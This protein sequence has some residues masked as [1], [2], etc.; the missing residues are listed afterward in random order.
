[1][2]STSSWFS[3]LLHMEIYTSQQTAQGLLL[4]STQKFI[5]ALA[6]RS[7][8]GYKKGKVFHLCLAKLKAAFLGTESPLLNQ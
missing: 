6:Y 1:M 4:S 5:P 3:P 2:G 8:D 7:K